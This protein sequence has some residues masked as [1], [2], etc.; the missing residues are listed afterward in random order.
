MKLVRSLSGRSH[1]RE[2]ASSIFASWTE[3]RLNM[4]MVAC[5]EDCI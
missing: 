4:L 3:L 1:Q 5:P 2:L